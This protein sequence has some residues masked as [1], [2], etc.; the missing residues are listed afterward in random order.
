MC[1]M[2]KKT[3]LK[4]EWCTHKAALFAVS[5]WHY[6]KSLPLPPL[7]KFGVYE[8]DCFCGVVIFSR[9]ASKDLMNQFGLTQVDGCELSRIALTKHSTPISRIVSICLKLL[10]RKFP[11]FKIVV[12]F[13]DPEQGHIGSIYQAGNWI[14]LGMSN[15][16][17]IYVDRRGKKIHSRM[18]S[19]SGIIKAFG[20][21][22][23]ALKPNDCKVLEVSGKH[24]YAFPL[25][26][27]M[28]SFL[29]AKAKQYPK[30]IV[31]VKVA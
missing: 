10:K 9:G 15:K 27:E 6:S 30:S 3:Q 29:K 24:K 21:T 25:C 31:S 18:V 17:K 22:Q 20:V 12:S 4:I 26:Q 1:L 28:E 5:K 8:N 14:Y 16:S 2:Q 19:P 23:K 11:L 7:V 13:A